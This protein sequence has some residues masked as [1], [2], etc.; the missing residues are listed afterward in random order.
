MRQIS[1]EEAISFYPVV[2]FVG[3]PALAY[4][5]AV[6]TLGYLVNDKGRRISVDEWTYPLGW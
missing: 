5:R 4:N 2:W 1:L 6:K 3:E